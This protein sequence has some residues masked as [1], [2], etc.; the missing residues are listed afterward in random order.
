MKNFMGLVCVGGRNC[1]RVVLTDGYGI[2]IRTYKF[3][4][5]DSGSLVCSSVS[6]IVSQI[7]VGFAICLICVYK[8]C[9]S[10]C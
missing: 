2:S 1:R 4:V 8:F 10:I 6:N 5:R 9:C 7:D 3:T